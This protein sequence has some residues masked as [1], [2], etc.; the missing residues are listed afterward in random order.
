MVCLLF[1]LLNSVYGLRK[2]TLMKKLVFVLIFVS[3]VVTTNADQ[4][5]NDIFCPYGM[6]SSE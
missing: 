6:Y 5:N 4:T 2:N 1:V 3:L